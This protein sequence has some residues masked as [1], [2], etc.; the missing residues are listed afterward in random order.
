MNELWAMPKAACSLCR[1]RRESADDGKWRHGHMHV[2]LM[3]SFD[4]VGRVSFK[5]PGFQQLTQLS[6][7]HRGGHGIQR[8]WWLGWGSFP[9]RLTLAICFFSEETGILQ[10]PG[11]SIHLW[12][13]VGPVS[14]SEQAVSHTRSMSA[15][16]WPHIT[17]LGP[18]PADLT[19]AREPKLSQRPLFLAYSLSWQWRGGGS[20]KKL[21]AMWP[22]V[23]W[24]T[25]LCSFPDMMGE[26]N[27]KGYITPINAFSFTPS[28]QLCMWLWRVEEVGMDQS[29]RKGPSES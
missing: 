19:R 12:F 8:T 21:T 11:V 13:S 17:H 29:Q 16:T 7:D 28:S 2:F 6:Q 14:L 5:H 23:N 26:R 15:G 9:S 3:S 24:T 22:L 4:V 1:P 27:R 10:L 20:G 18:I 25:D